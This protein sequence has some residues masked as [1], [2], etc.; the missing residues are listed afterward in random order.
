MQTNIID[1]GRCLTTDE[2]K[3]EKMKRTVTFLMA[4]LML[5]VASVSVAATNEI[6]EESLSRLRGMCVQEVKSLKGS[7]TLEEAAAFQR[8]DTDG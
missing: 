5:L 2:G 1:L 3:G 6:E 7:I 4:V 8:G